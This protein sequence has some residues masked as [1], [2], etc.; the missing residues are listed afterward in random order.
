MLKLEPLIELINVYHFDTLF[1]GLIT[2]S[3]YSFLS[4][5][6]SGG[7]MSVA[8]KL[9][10]IKLI[11][12][13]SE[14]IDPAYVYR[15]FKAVGVSGETPNIEGDLYR[16]LKP[17]FS[18]ASEAL[19]IP[20]ANTP[21]TQDLYFH[22]FVFIKS[23]IL[24]FGKKNETVPSYDN[25]VKQTQDFIDLKK[26]D[27]TEVPEWKVKSG[28]R[29]LFHWE[30]EVIHFLYETVKRPPTIDDR[31][32]HIK[33]AASLL[34]C[35]NNYKGNGARI[36]FSVE[37]PDVPHTL[38]SILTMLREF[39]ENGIEV[40]IAKGA[41]RY[42]EGRYKD[43]VIQE[44]S[45]VCHYQNQKQKDLILAWI[46]PYGQE[47]YLHIDLENNVA[48]INLRTSASWPLGTWQ[49]IPRVKPEWLKNG[50]GYSIIGSIFFGTQEI[51]E[52]KKAS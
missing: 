33:T 51:I 20:I 50:E 49:E 31:I 36:I 43:K 3:S 47:S 29:Y 6:L 15:L 41:F 27:S 11:P 28:K 1:F 46:E 23:Y 5:E 26:K 8:P 19:G 13:I 4:D 44:I 10:T 18:T 48:S 17:Y 30:A 34:L 45:M 39:K 24:I 2:V 12:K 22:F 42:T 16:F 35:G 37:H 21:E 38:T 7:S 52:R 9:K 40:Q 14:E 25:L 32:R